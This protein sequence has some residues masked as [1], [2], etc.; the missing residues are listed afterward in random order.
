M[1]NWKGE[2]LTSWSYDDASKTYNSPFW[3]FHRADLHRCLVDH[4]LALGGRIICN[5]RVDDVQCDEEQHQA[6]VIVQKGKRYSA[7]LVVGADGLH[8]QLRRIITGHDEPPTPTGDLAYR[9]LLDASKVRANPQLAHFIANPEVN[10][11][12]GPG[13]HVGEKP[14]TRLCLSLSLGNC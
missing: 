2:L 10:T 9:L 4:V 12:I 3:D 6:T 8:T 11:W 1:W 14:S 5:S 13:A 7:D